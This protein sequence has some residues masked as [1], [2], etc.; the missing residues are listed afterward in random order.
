MNNAE[1][2]TASNAG[3]EAETLDLI[4]TEIETGIALLGA[5][6]TEYAAANRD[7]GNALRANAQTVCHQAETH[8]THADARRYRVPANLRETLRMLKDRIEAAG[9]NNP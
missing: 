9:R 1:N 6:M 3:V 5:A 4:A 8:M 7:R 2:G